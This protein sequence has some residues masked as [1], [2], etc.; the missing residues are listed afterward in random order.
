MLK[1]A[2]STLSHHFQPIHSPPDECRALFA[3]ASSTCLCREQTNLWWCVWRETCRKLLALGILEVQA[4]AFRS[5]EQ[6]WQT[7][8]TRSKR[9]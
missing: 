3:K 6:K 9:T 2:A 1:A 5:C 8:R 7:S 4:T